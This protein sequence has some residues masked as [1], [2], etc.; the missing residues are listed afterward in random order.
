MH[1]SYLEDPLEGVLPKGGAI[2]AHHVLHGFQAASEP[3]QL[4]AELQAMSAQ[5]LPVDS[6]AHQLC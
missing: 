3:C 1:C 5:V 4:P 6:E 2:H